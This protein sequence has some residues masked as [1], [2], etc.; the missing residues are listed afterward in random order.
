MRGIY[1][2]IR[3]INNTQVDDAHD[4]HIVMPNYNFIKYSHNYLK[5]FGILLQ[6][7]KDEPVSTTSAINEFNAANA[8]TDLFKIK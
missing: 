7:C 1:Q 8:T 5:T 3:R 6:Y 4:F 2:L